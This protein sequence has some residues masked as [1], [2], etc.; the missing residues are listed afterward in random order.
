MKDSDMRNRLLKKY[1]VK[2]KGMSVVKEEIK[3]RVKVKAAKVKRY[4]GRVGQFHQNRLFNINQRQL[5]KELDGKCDNSQVGPG[6]SGVAFG[7][8]PVDITDKRMVS[9][10]ERRVQECTTTRG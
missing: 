4:D 10:C 2:G 5:F 3:Q 7:I 1:Q 8:S 6:L 9:R